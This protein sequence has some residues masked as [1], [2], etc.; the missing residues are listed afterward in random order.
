[1]T[2]PYIA[3]HRGRL[4]N[5]LLPFAR[6]VFTNVT[7]TLLGIP[8]FFILNRTTIIGRSEVPHRRNTLLLSNHQSMIDSFLVGVCAYWPRSFLKPFLIPWNPAAQENFYHPWWLGLLS[9]LWKCIPVRPGRRDPK[10][11][12]RMM[13]ALE[14]GTMTLF[15]EGT[16]TRDGSIGRGRPG[17]GLLILGNRPTVVPVTIVGMDRV[18]PI[19]SRFPRLFQRIYV[20]YGEPLD[21]SNFLERSRSKETAQQ[22]VDRAMET[23]RKQQARV[24]E[25]KSGS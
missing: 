19:R 6:Y 7:V 14:S 1:M 3:E 2:E 13:R 22:L 5:L 15:P 10:A 21:Y 24:E 17:A 18:L 25:L 11:L 8:L 16:R 4:F 12:Y 23:L 20:Y 9:D